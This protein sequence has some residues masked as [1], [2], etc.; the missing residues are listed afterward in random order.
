MHG[1][2]TDAVDPHA[3]SVAALQLWLIDYFYLIAGILFALAGASTACMRSLPGSFQVL[4]LDPPPH[5][6]CKVCYRASTSAMT[7]ALMMCGI[8]PSLTGQ[9]LVKTVP[10]KSF[11]SH[12]EIGQGFVSC[13]A[14]RR[15]GP[16]GCLIA[17]GGKGTG[18]PPQ[19]LPT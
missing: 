10:C 14:H 6:P 5:N 18:L 9:Q 8:C 3:Y 2:L 12:P 13:H 11:S 19:G 7:P 15:G 1:L 17:S 16:G 4:T